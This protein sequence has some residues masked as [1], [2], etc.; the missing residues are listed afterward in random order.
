[1]SSGTTLFGQQE[2][3]VTEDS[4]NRRRVE[5][6]FHPFSVRVRRRSNN[7]L[8]Y[9][10]KFW[11]AQMTMDILFNRPY[12]RSRKRCHPDDGVPSDYHSIQ[13]TRRVA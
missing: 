7:E 10:A 2:I 4:E 8:D 6:F 12:F 5:L 1:M 9:R 13:S 3:H 11:L